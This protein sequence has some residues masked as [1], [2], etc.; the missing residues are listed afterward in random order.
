MKIV[1]PCFNRPSLLCRDSVVGNRKWVKILPR[2]KCENQ[3]SIKAIKS[4]GFVVLKTLFFVCYKM[5]QLLLK[6]DSMN[7]M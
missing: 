3:Q 1:T 7:R 4:L 5:L 6:I 2:Y